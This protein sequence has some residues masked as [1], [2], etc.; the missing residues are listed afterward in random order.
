MKN[1]KDRH[2]WGKIFLLLFFCLGICVS[3]NAQGEKAR[4]SEAVRTRQHDRITTT[5]KATVILTDDDIR[6]VEV[7]GM[8]MEKERLQEWAKRLYTTTGAT[9]DSADYADEY[10]RFMNDLEKAKALKW[11]DMSRIIAIPTVPEPSQKAREALKIRQED[12]MRKQETETAKKAEELKKQKETAVKEE[13]L[14]KQKAEEIKKE[15][16]A[17][18]KIEMEK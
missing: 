10:M 1:A 6:S 14:K 8:E 15:E 12:E 11:W 13:Q 17:K 4:P 18:K 2:R 16:E 9:L 3:V 7:T 5:G